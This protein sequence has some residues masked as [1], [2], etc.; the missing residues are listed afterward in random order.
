MKKYVFPIFCGLSLLYA[1]AICA[2]EVVPD[3]I[4]PVNLSEVIVVSSRKQINPQQHKKP[5]SGLDEYLESSRNITMIKRGGYAWEPA[6]NGMTS[7]RLSVT[8]DGMQIFGACTD[9]MDPVTSY[10]D[11]SNLEAIQI[12]SGQDGAAFGNAIGGAINLKLN[13]PNFRKKRMVGNYWKFIRNQ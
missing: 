5:L 6:M 10:V 3:S 4:L 9:K 13:N 2:Q 1:S 8:I 12:S 7:E 11:V